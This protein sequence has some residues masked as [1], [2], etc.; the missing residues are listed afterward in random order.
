MSDKAQLYRVPTSLDAPNRLV[1]LPL[2]EALPAFALF[3]LLFMAGDLIWAFVLGAAVV[4]GLKYLK[5][6]Q[7]RGYVV[8]LMYWYLPSCL[9][10]LLL[11]HTPPSHQ[12]HYLA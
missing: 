11:A 2:D 7:G 1:G 8:S 4:V 3:V 9:T 6:G 12:R 5:R 10:A